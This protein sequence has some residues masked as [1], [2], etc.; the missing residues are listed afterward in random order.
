MKTETKIQYCTKC[1]HYMPFKG[2]ST[3]EK[4]ISLAKCAKTESYEPGYVAPIK[5][6]PKYQFCE[7]V[8]GGVPTCDDYEVS[9]E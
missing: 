3:P 6:D 2:A 9:D 5:Y 4:A 8:R 1:N 7:I